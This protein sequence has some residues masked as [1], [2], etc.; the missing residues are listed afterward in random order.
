MAALRSYADVDI[1]RDRRT[2][3]VTRQTSIIAAT[4]AAGV[5]ATDLITAIGGSVSVPQVVASSAIIVATSVAGLFAT[6]KLDVLRKGSGTVYFLRYQFPGMANWHT[7]ELRT[8]AEKLGHEDLRAITREVSNRPDRGVID[9][10]DDVK[11]I[12]LALE[13]ALN[14]D[15]AQTGI[16][17]AVDMQWMAAMA[18]GHRMY[19]RWD[20]QQLDEMRTDEAQGIQEPAL[21]WHLIDPPAGVERF[22][23]ITSIMPP[24]SGPGQAQADIVLVTA[25]LTPNI[26]LTKLDGATLVASPPY[27]RPEM[28]RDAP[29]YGVGVFVTEAADGAADTLPDIS[30]VTFDTPCRGVTMANDPLPGESTSHPWLATVACVNALRTALHAY[31]DALIVFTAQLPKTVGLALGWHLTRDELPVDQLS[32]LYD[33]SQGSPVF[34]CTRPCCADPWRRLVP[35]YF[36][37]ET[38][39]NI[40]VRVQASQPPAEELRVRLGLGGP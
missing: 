39:G 31:P 28:W 38:Q 16:R 4:S 10:I 33:D 14:T 21:G 34:R 5:L 27:C 30:A 8:L 17:L 35:L 22:T 3:Q 11:D 7:R 15:D 37:L 25:N 13:I 32:R 26:R 24:P 18:V 9:M 1:P 6:H 29:W 40:A 19:G 23:P 36:D 2:W 12:C 20:T